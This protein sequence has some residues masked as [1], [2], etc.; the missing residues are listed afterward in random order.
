MDTRIHSLAWSS[1]HPPHSL[2]ALRLRLRAGLRQSGRDFTS[3]SPRGLTRLRIKAE[4]QIPRG[5][6]PARNGKNKRLRRWPKGQ[7][8]PKSLFSARC[9]AHGSNKCRPA[10][11]SSCVV[12]VF[13]P[14]LFANGG[15]KDGAPTVWEV[16]TKRPTP[17]KEGGMGHPGNRCLPG[18]P[19]VRASYYSGTKITVGDDIV[20]TSQ[21]WEPGDVSFSSSISSRSTTASSLAD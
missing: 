6:K 21:R 9:Y 16:E 8:Y 1:S 3:D 10:G 17:P 11:W 13:V 12:T 20:P 4:K 7:L 15:E 2:F 18:P 19:A 14:T 5:L